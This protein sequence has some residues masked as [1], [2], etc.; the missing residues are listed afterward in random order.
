MTYGH[1]TTHLGGEE[2]L[3]D[4]GLEILKAEETSRA[5]RKERSRLESLWWAGALI[6]AGLVFAADSLGQLPQIGESD[7][8]TWVFLGAGL[9]GM[10]GNLYRIANSNSPNPTAWDHIWSAGLLIIGLAGMPPVDIFWPL[11]LVLVGV[12]ILAETLFRRS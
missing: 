1:K 7:A 11:I 6:W 8:W 2:Q 9:Y 3:T 10:L 5:E 4:V 12:V